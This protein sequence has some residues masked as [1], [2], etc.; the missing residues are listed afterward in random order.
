MNPDFKEFIQSLNIHDVRYLIVGG[1]A[2]A[3]HGH[4]RY[5][6][7]LDV[8][9]DCT[10]ENALNI[11]LALKDFGFGSLNLEPE[12]FLI[13]NQTIQL[14]CPPR[15]IDIL[16][17]VSGIVFDDCFD[18]RI[19]T[20]IDEVYANYIDLDNLLKNKKASGRPQDLADLD[21]LT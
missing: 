14:G 1:Y 10:S 5:T 3:H 13:P 8:W 7:D 16:T 4:P 11:I 20:K 18:S 17:S 6:K 2:V 12:D 15:K 21:N 19:V 9:I